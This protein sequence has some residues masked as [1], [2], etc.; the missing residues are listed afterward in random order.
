ML[1]LPFLILSVQ[2]ASWFRWSSKKPT[3]SKT[4][5]VPTEI[6]NSVDK[7]WMMV[8]EEREGTHNS[9]DVD[10]SPI[11]EEREAAAEAKELPNERQE[12]EMPNEKLKEEMPKSK[13]KKVFEFVR[14]ESPKSETE[15][16]GEEHKSER[17]DTS[18]DMD[19]ISGPIEQS[20]V[21]SQLIVPTNHLVYQDYN[22]STSGDSLE[23]SSV[24]EDLRRDYPTNDLIDSQD[25]KEVLKMLTVADIKQ[26]LSLSTVEV[27]TY[28]PFSTIITGNEEP[29]NTI[30]I[31]RKSTE[32]RQESKT[33]NTGFQQINELR[34]R[35]ISPEAKSV[36]STTGPDSDDQDSLSSCLG[37]CDFELSAAFERVM[38]TISR[39]MTPTRPPPAQ[40][41]ISDSAGDNN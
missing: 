39:A 16:E 6:Q 13:E 30:S 36:D 27:K 7:D 26:D 35:R 24:D 9:I 18:N 5:T 11:R 33:G 1:L 21:T 19:E 12:E 40:P 8:D 37:G 14:P 20:V 23:P 22:E 4:T 32:I 28:T 3:D 2:G 41:G 15:E 17:E 10:R 38:S 25:P 31:S 34:A 29:E